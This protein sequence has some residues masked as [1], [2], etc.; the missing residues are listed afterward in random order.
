M[1]KLNTPLS[2]EL[3]D[4]TRRHFFGEC[5]VGLGSSALNCLLARDGFGAPRRPQIDPNTPLA[6][7]KPPQPARAKRVIYLFMAGG[8]SQLELFTD[9]PKLRELTGQEPPESL[10]K[11]KRFAFLKGNE[12]LLGSKRKFA[13]YGQSGMQLSELLPQDRKSVE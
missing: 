11:G 13:R 3:R 12:T 1:K 2:N 4:V 5:A 6:R 10:M 8:P 9:K 7:R